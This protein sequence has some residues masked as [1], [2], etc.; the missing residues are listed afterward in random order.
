MGSAIHCLLLEPDEFKDR[1]IIAPP[2]NRRTNA[3]KAEEAEF[4]PA[5]QSWA[6][7]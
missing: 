5:A 1:F 3:G 6:R 7:R 4:Q 2:F